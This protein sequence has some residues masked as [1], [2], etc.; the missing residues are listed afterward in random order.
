[1]LM[2]TKQQSL[3]Q[4]KEAAGRRS[5]SGPRRAEQRPRRVHPAAIVAR[6]KAGSLT[7]RDV[8]QLQAAFGNRAVTR[9]L[10]GAP[11]RASS[12]DRMG[13]KAVAAARPAEVLATPGESESAHAE[14]GVGVVQLFSAAPA[15]PPNAGVRGRHLN[16]SGVPDESHVTTRDGQA[17]DLVGTAP[18]GHP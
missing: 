10:T 16:A 13:V 2:S 3:V 8:L 12:Q 11:R 1:M 4:P 6:A 9:L 18:G 14:G 15:N 5:S 7:P 17:N